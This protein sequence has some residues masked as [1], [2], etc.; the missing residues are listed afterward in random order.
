MERP[1][2][3]VRQTTMPSTASPGADLE[4]TIAIKPSVDPGLVA[5]Q[6]VRER[7]HGPVG[8]QRLAHGPLPV[9]PARRIRL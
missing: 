5:E 3:T 9:F 4:H 1:D 8:L 7:V 2:S 6:V